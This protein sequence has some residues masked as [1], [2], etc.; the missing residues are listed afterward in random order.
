MCA[1]ECV[2][3]LIEYEFVWQRSKYSGEGKKEACTKPKRG[4]RC[5]CCCCCLS[6]LVAAAA[7]DVAVRVATIDAVAGRAE[8]ERAAKNN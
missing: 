4:Q 2:I 6:V 8:K 1:F 7:V 3:D 5:W